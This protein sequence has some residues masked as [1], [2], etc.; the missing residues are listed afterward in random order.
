MMTSVFEPSAIANVATDGDT[1]AT[2]DV[3]SEHAASVKAAAAKMVAREIFMFLRRE[4][5]ARSKRLPLDAHGR[6][7]SVVLVSSY[8]TFARDQGKV[9]ILQQVT[10]RTGQFRTPRIRGAG[11]S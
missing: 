9:H 1:G 4:V 8:D 11:A 7:M 10:C 3:D 5:D 6:V 2:G